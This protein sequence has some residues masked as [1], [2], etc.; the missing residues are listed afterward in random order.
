M[1]MFGEVCWFPYLLC[2]LLCHFMFLRHRCVCACDAFCQSE[3]H[4]LMVSVPKD[5]CV[6][7]SCV[8]QHSGA[9][10]ASGGYFRIVY[11]CVCPSGNLSTLREDMR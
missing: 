1:L 8:V 4:S 11:L 10:E 7:S 3:S 5:G 6:G 2:L 9:S